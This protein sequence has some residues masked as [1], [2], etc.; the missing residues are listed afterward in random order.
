MKLKHLKEQPLLEPPGEAAYLRFE[1][2]PQDRE[3]ITK[4]LDRVRRD[5]DAGTLAFFHC[6]MLDA[7]L[8][9]DITNADR[10]SMLGVWENCRGRQWLSNEESDER[11]YMNLSYYLTRL[12]IIPN[13]VDGLPV[14]LREKLTR[15]RNERDGVAVAELHRRLLGIGP[16]QKVTGGDKKAMGEAL[17]E[18]RGIKGG[19]RLAELLGDLHR[20]G[21]LEEVTDDDLQTI[22][23]ALA[24][25]RKN[26]DG[27]KLA[28]IYSGLGGLKIPDNKNPTPPVPPLKEYVK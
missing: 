5:D 6:L 2:A 14:Y 11:D 25:E 26:A 24:R 7:G 8:G 12:G 1:V 15:A 18:A 22:M 9:A 16:P 4:R 23:E 27:L 20:I 13:V 3:L 17:D 21:M 19:I 28:R 10:G